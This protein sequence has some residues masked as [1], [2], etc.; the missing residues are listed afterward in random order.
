MTAWTRQARASARQVAAAV[1]LLAG[2][3]SSTPEFQG[4]STDE[5]YERAVQAYAQEDWDE[6]ARILAD[7]IQS[8][9]PRS[10][11]VH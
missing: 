9:R 7:Y 10:A 2:A 8:S 1:V 6:A 5:V 11:M 3:C 4:M